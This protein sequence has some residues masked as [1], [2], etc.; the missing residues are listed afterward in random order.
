MNNYKSLIVVLAMSCSAS[1]LLAVDYK[2]HFQDATTGIDWS[3]VVDTTTNTL[4]I[5]EWTATGN[6]FYPTAISENNPVVFNAVTGAN[7]SYDIA[8]VW[9]GTMPN[10]GFLSELNWA[11]Y[12][13]TNK[14]AQESG[15]GVAFF[16]SEPSKIGLG[17]KEV[18]Q[19][20]I[21]GDDFIIPAGNQRTYT[22]AQKFT[23]QVN[24]NSE[25]TATNFTVEA[26]PE[27]SSVMLLLVGATGL[28][29]RRKR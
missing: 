4:S 20:E 23:D 7:S 14:P 3:G 28:L 6:D 8:D 15:E 19:P 26:V 5:T 9:D 27:P 24:G 29:A 16:S 2:I 25:I 10:W 17:V 21:R 12:N 1:P 22:G 18:F 11:N 13:W